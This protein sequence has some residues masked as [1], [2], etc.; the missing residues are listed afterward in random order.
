MMATHRGIPPRKETNVSAREFDWSKVKTVDRT[1]QAQPDQPA[2]LV[3]HE[4]AHALIGYR[5]GM[6]VQFIDMT[7]LLIPSPVCGLDSETVPVANR[8]AA[9]GMAALAGPVGEAL[10]S[11]GEPRW[12]QDG[13]VARTS[14]KALA[15]DTVGQLDLLISWQ[16]QVKAMLQADPA[17]KP[18]VHALDRIGAM[19]GPEVQAFIRNAD[20]AAGYAPERVTV[21]GSVVKAAAGKAAALVLQAKRG[22]RNATK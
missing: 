15:P 17:Y 5:L 6:E 8:A 12:R 16:R 3:W 1:P 2:P 21:K 4:A 7:G 22:L 19:T 14:A 10:A 13:E 18:L 20:K 9:T 11:G